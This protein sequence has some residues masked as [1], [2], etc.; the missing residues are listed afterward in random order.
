MSSVRKGRNI[1]AALSKKGFQ[2]ETDGDHIRY[3]LT[4]T[5]V[6]TK[7][8]HGAMGD[9]IGANLISRMARQLHLTKKTISCLDRLSIGR[10]RLSSDTSGYWFHLIVARWRK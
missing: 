9:T 4:G 10:S 6:K 2:R 5:D 3:V 1:D 8:S 7:I